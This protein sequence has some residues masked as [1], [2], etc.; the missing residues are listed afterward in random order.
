VGHEAGLG[1]GM[2]Y[3]PVLSDAYLAAVVRYDNS[4]RALEA[5]MAEFD[6]AKTGAEAAWTAVEA[7]GQKEES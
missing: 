6:E 7:T 4:Q 1:V 3:D 2:K 5:A